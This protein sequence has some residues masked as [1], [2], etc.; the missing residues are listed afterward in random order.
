VSSL[1]LKYYFTKDIVPLSK[2]KQ[3]YV[4]NFIETV[5]EFE[6]EVFNNINNPEARLFLE[7][8]KLFIITNGFCFILLNTN[9]EIRQKIYKKL[10][11]SKGGENYGYRYFGN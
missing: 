6:T 4:T 3:N 1:K 8:E 9:T 7:E 2:L 5:E 10:Q 11:E